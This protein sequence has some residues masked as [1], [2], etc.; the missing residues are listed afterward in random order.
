VPRGDREDERTAALGALAQ[1]GGDQAVAVLQRVLA[2]RDPC[3]APLRRRA[4]FLLSQQRGAETADALLRVA[5]SDP[6]REVREQAVFWL[7]QVRTP[8]ATDLLLGIIGGQGDA[9]IKEKAVY[10]LGQQRTERATQALRDLAARDGAP[11]ALREKAIF[12][13]GQQ[14]TADNAA[15][16]RGLYGRLGDAQLKEAVLFAV[17][18]QRADGSGEW[19]LDLAQNGRE[20]LELR[21]KALFW[22]SQGGATMAQLG[23]LYGRVTDREMREQ[24]VFAYS[25]RREPEAVDRL[26]EVARRDADPELRKRAIFWLGQS[27]DPRA[28][29]FLVNLLE[30]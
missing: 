29:Q 14:R 25:Q 28:A 11:R 21:K 15:F 3:S 6:D 9:G 18:Q 4:V 1:L 17:S 26:I 30:R 24:L 27:R 12:W 5:Q 23:A 8:R 16:L 20:P 22:A 13:I 10:A 7:S 19:L 2:R